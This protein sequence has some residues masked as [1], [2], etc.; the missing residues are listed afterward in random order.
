MK[1]I[2]QIGIGLSQTETI[3]LQKSIEKL[4][5]GKPLANAHF[6]GKVQGVERDYY[7]C[8]AE[9]NDGERPHKEATEEEEKA[10]DPDETKVQKT[11]IEEDAGPNTYNYFVCT[12]LGGKWTLLPD[13]TPQQIIASRS[14]KQLYTGNLGAPVVAPPNRFEG[15][16]KELLRA[17][18]ARVVHCCTISPKGQY[19]PE[20]EPEED[21]PLESNAPIALNEEWAPKPVTGLGHFLHRLPA[22]LPQG[23]VEFWAPEAEE[24]EKERPIEKGPPILRPLTE[25][26]PLDG[27]IP[28]WTLKQFTHPAKLFWLRSNTWPGLSILT[29]ANADKIVMH[30]YGWGS[31]ITGAIEW[32]P[33]PEP[34]KK[35]PP[36][37]E[38]EEEE[39][40]GAEKKQP[41]GEEEESGEA[42]E[43][44][45]P[46]AT[47]PAK[48]PPKPQE[49]E[50][51]TESGSYT[52]SGYD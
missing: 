5:R 44:G 51:G 38:E 10:V 20:E 3:L 48:T 50:S 13:V 14:V 4:V 6:W 43:G 29:S 39:E 2:G 46:P 28:S 27:K 52:G 26:E 30:Y 12:T 32:P 41:N 40:E 17:F 49:P 11:P 1:F 31:K 23:R 47:K 16:E 19:N 21:K 33:L 35:P 8:E 22:I 7:I 42:D 24:E 18:I 34:K 45:A 15:T 25:D 37:V 9:F 36:P